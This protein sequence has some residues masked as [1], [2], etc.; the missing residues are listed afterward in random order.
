MDLKN[1][2]GLEVSSQKT[3]LLSEVTQILIHSKSSPCLADVGLFVQPKSQQSLS[4]TK[5]LP[6][7]SSSYLEDIYA[8]RDSLHCVS[9]HILREAPLAAYYSSSLL[10]QA[11]LTWSRTLLSILRAQLV[12]QRL[13]CAPRGSNITHTHDYVRGMTLIPIVRTRDTIPKN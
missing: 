11:R 1:L 10:L 12:L 13:Y 7:S 6:V 9:A 3:S 5:S 4:P 8:L 2:Q